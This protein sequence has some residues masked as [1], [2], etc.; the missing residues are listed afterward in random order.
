MVNANGVNGFYGFTT[1]TNEADPT[2]TWQATVKVG[3]ATF[4]HPLRIETIMPNRL[5]IKMDFGVDKIK[6]GDKLLSGDLGVKWLHGAVAKNLQANIS[7]Q[8]YKSSSQNFLSLHSTIR[9]KVFIRRKWKYTL[10][11]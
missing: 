3:G 11:G 10:V 4:T 1:T 8:L 7:V 9:R 6:A 5:K 2:G